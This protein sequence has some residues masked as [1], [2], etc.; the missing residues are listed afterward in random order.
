MGVDPLELQ[1]VGEEGGVVGGNVDAGHPVQPHGITIHTNTPGFTAEIKAGND[2]NGNTDFHTVSK[3]AAQTINGETT[4][5]LGLHSAQRYFV[6]WIT[7][8]PP[9]SGSVHINEVTAT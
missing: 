6:I 4:I 8:L 5:Q 7:K 3:G 9:G 1:L 2:P